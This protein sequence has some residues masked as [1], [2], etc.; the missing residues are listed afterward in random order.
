MRVLHVRQELTTE[1]EETSVIQAVLEADIERQTLLKEER[2]LL[3]RLESA[4]GGSSEP[5]T[6]EEKKKKLEAKEGDDAKFSEDLNQLKDVYE[7]LQLLSSAPKLRAPWCTTTCDFYISFC[8][9]DYPNW[10][11]LKE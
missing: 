3:A 9:P 10:S 5:A 4:D 6:I 1:N 2:E 7:R 8:A 11:E